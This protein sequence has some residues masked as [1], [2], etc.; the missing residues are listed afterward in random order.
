V[1]C[2]WLRRF[3]NNAR[4]LLMGP[5]RFGYYRAFRRELTEAEARQMDAWMDGVNQKFDELHKELAKMPVPMP[6]P[7][8][9]QTREGSE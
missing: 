8:A 3:Y 7:A 1:S 6:K 4:L 5:R 9:Q 2:E